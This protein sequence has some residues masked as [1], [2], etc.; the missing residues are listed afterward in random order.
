MERERKEEG[1]R[2]ESGSKV[3]KMRKREERREKFRKNKKEERY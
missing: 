3:R 2:E 1:G